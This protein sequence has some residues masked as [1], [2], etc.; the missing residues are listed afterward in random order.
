MERLRGERLPIIALLRLLRAAVRLSALLPGSARLRATGAIIR[1]PTA[2]PL[3][4]ASHCPFLFRNVLH[5]CGCRSVM[6]CLAP[7][8]AA[9]ATWCTDR[10]AGNAHAAVERRSQRRRAGAT[11]IIVAKFHVAPTQSVRAHAR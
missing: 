6:T 11:R 7:A 9:R 3:L 2:L 4:I 1:L 10:D 8:R 5:C